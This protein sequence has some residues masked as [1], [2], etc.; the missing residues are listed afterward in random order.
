MGGGL[1]GVR[2]DM[3]KPKLFE[4]HLYCCAGAARSNL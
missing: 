3:F 4:P 1:L 2:F